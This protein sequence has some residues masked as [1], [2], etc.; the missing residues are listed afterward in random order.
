MW[1]LLLRVILAEKVILEEK[2]CDINILKYIDFG[3]VILD[4]PLFMLIIYF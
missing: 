1:I 4:N 3:G 2:N